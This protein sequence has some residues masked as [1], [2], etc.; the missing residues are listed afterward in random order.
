MALQIALQLHKA[1]SHQIDFIDIV[2]LRPVQYQR[3]LQAVGLEVAGKTG[4]LPQRCLQ[5][6]A[7][8][9]H[10]H[11]ADHH[12]KQPIAQ[13][14]AQNRIANLL[15]VVATTLPDLQRSQWNAGSGLDGLRSRNIHLQHGRPVCSWWNACFKK[16]PRRRRPHA[17]IADLRQRTQPLHLLS[18]HGRVYIPQSA[19]Q[20]QQT[21]VGMPLHVRLEA[22]FARLIFP[23][24]QQA[25]KQTHANQRQQYDAGN[26]MGGDG[27]ETLMEHGRQ[28][29]SFS[30]SK[31]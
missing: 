30:I 1:S 28:R 29:S 2:A 4:N 6:P 10:D 20:Q 18:N 26:Q 5:L 19:R 24:G 3:L 11:G 9:H 22:A 12:G 27:A 13:N 21:A 8:H 16:L 17:H 14:H 31:L 7:H 25:H 23:G 15:E